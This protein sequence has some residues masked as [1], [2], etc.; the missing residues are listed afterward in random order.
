[1][2]LVLAINNITGLDK[3][4]CYTEKQYFCN[5]RYIGNIVTKYKIE[6]FSD[7]INVTENLSDADLSLPTLIVGWEATKSYFPDADI[8]SMKVRDN[9]YWT[10]SPKFRM[11]KFEVDYK[12]FKNIVI[13]ELLKKIEYKYFSIL[14]YSCEDIKKV[15]R[16]LKSRKVTIFQHKNMMYGLIGTKV[17]G[18]SLNDAEYIGINKSKVIKFL[19]NCNII[20]SND[21]LSDKDKRTF[22]GNNIVVPYLYS[23]RF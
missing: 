6:V 19:E 1:M 7:F 21:F 5:M 11:S 17:I 14:T 20:Q 3:F 10:H 23:L 18:F 15:L 8:L 13:K 12:L 16:F 2:A 4:G 9:I 22:Y